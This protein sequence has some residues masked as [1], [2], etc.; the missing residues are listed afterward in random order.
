MKLSVIMP[1]YNVE[2]TLARA[3]ESVL[4]QETD[5]SCE[6][7]IVDDASTDRTLELAKE[8][9][10]KYPQIKVLQNEEN[11]GNAFSFYTALCASRGDYFCVLDG[12]DYYTVRD[13]LQRQLD[14][15]DHDEK[16]EY[17][18]T[19]THYIVDL[20]EG[21]VHIPVRSKI[22][23]F[24]YVDFLTQNS[25]YYHTATYVYRNIFRGAVPLEMSD[26]L[27]R[28]DTPR[29]MF[30]L[31]YSGKKIR[32]LDFVGSA[33]VFEGNGIWSG[34]KQT[35]QFEYQ[36]NYQ[37]RHKENVTTEFEREAADKTIVRNR[38]L[39]TTAKRDLRKY[40]LLTI[41]EAVASV[42]PYVKKFAFAQK[43]YV[44]EKVYFSEYIDSLLSSLGRVQR[45]RFPKYC[46]K[47]ASNKNVCII[48]GILNPTG[49]GIFS[50]I[51]D[52]I[53]ILKDKRVF[54]F[55]TNMPE[56]P[57]ETRDILKRHE[58]LTIVCAPPEVKSRLDW[59]RERFVEISPYRCYCYCSHHDVIGP[60]LI[61]S[62][63]CENIALFSFDHGYVCGISNGELDK[64]AAK[65]SVD[66]RLLSKSFPRKRV[67]LLP[68]WSSGA[69]D[70]EQISYQP[71]NG[72][73]QLITACGAARFYKVDGQPPYRYLDF[74]F[75]LLA[76]TG[77]QH[78]HF[79]PLPEKVLSEIRDRSKGLGLQAGAF[80]HI[81]WSNNI[82]RDL[83]AYNVDLFIEP[84][85]VVS[86]KLTLDVLSAGVPVIARKSP[87]RMRTTDFIPPGSLYW[88][89]RQDFLSTLANLTP[90]RLTAAS[91]TA[92]RYFKEN[93]SISAAA[94]NI[95]EN[96][97]CAV[98]TAPDFTDDRIL[99]IADS[100]RLFGNSFQIC[101]QTTP[102]ER[103]V[104]DRN[105]GKLRRIWA[106]IQLS[107]HSPGTAIKKIGEK[108]LR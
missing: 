88:S 29:T 37:T 47:Q 91:Q 83:L 103:I 97:G 22:R 5:F 80:V 24:N 73:R 65:R 23:E 1:C 18:G 19:A 25:G 43:D 68:A 72:H 16:R 46:Q 106:F 98:E 92:K 39:L 27:Y 105:A 51:D 15:L 76:A 63:V 104:A 28:G 107:L 85:P 100:L 31:K 62:G 54:L 101:I 69:V 53:G 74:I 26:V 10:A 20:G 99:D 82:P 34:L 44:L 21:R 4:W 38:L 56:I 50:E 58:H 81:P 84:F 49:G 86:Y 2:E 42:S 36:I 40:P 87:E 66:Y 33:Y 60:A 59:F 70:C 13:K 89:S 102:Q 79:G 75:D 57:P 90:A 95:I 30:H 67:M 52:L 7:L 8:Y 78:Y 3:I 14:F 48:E 96:Q 71:F 45:V 9:Q 108:I 11:K 32:V 6:I 35:Q 93:F 41:D 77:G 61:E 17:V 64:L 55:V 12:D 94:K